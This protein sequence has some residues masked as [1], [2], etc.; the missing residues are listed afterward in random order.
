MFQNTPL[1]GG[2]LFDIALAIQGRDNFRSIEDWNGRIIRN[3][4]DGYFILDF[5]NIEK[6]QEQEQLLRK[7]R[8]EIKTPREGFQIPRM[9][10]VFEYEGKA[11]IILGIDDNLKGETNLFAYK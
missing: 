5:P 8:D 7:L 3:V 2:L 6:R 4:D 9:S 11:Y 1:S 10:G